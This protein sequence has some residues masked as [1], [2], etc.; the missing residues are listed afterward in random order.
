MVLA[1]HF[2][3]NTRAF[4]RGL[5]VS[6]AHVVHG[7]QNAPVHGLQAVAHVGD[8]SRHVDRHCVGDKGL[9]HFLVN[10]DLD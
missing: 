2:A 3:D 1:Q 9:F 5:V 6:V 7:K 8:C 4:F 10:L